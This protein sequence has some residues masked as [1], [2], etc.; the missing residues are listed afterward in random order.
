M[1]FGLSRTCALLVF[2]LTLSGVASAGT[3]LGTTSSLN[4]SEE[5]QKTWALILDDGPFKDPR[6]GREF[7]NH[8]ELPPQSKGYYHEYLVKAEDGSV[9]WN[10]RIVVGGSGADTEYFYTDNNFENYHRIQR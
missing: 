1:K 3:L 5:A 7:K 2:C 6:D 9:L 10:Q 8:D 4:M